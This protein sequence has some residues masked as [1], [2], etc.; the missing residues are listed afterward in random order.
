MDKSEKYSVMEVNE[1][2]MMLKFI[3]CSEDYP[4]NGEASNGQDAISP[5]ARQ[6]F[7]LVLL[8]INMPKMDG[9][10]GL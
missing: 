5:C 7:S 1:E 3:L 10:Q 4:V 2:S 6:K 9:L 8:D